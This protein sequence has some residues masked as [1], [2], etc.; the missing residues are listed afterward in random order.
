MKR[1][2]GIVDIYL[3]DFKYWSPEIAQKYS[4]AGDYP[5]VAKAAIAEMDSAEERAEFLAEI[6]L[7]ESGLA[8]LARAAYHLMGLRTY[9]TAGQDECRA[10]T[11][12]VGDTAPKAAGVIHTDFQRGFIKAEVYSYNDL[13]EYGSE[14]GIKAAGKYRMEGKEYLV[15]DGDNIFFKFNV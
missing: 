1:L 7:K 6:G 3:P 8:T 2:E 5:K 9:F 14:A 15:Q 12:K 10:W 11:I 13:V 4:H